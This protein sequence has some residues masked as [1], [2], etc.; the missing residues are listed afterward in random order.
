MTPSLFFHS[1]L[2]FPIDIQHCQILHVLNSVILRE[3]AENISTVL[4]YV[5]VALLCLE[6]DIIHSH[7]T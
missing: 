2:I 3:T 4:N 7:Q 5:S 1:R 6:T